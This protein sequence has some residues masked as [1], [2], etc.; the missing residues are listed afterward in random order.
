MNDVYQDRYISHQ[1]RKKRQL[2]L[3]EGTTATPLPKGDQKALLRILAH[4]RSQRVFNG[5]PL[6][7]GALDKILDAATTSP[8]SCNRHGVL[9]KVVTDRREKELLTGLL[10]GGVGWIHRADT[11][12]LFLTDPAAYK[13]PNEKD[14][15][16]YCDVGFKAMSMWLV[17]ETLG[18][19]VS[20]I[21]P[22][23]THPAIFRE[24]YGD[25]VF[26]GA[27]ALGCYDRDRR[28]EKA[29]RPER[30]DLLV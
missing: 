4:R 20:Y 29:D 9:I 27:L 17:A 6:P 26:C 15:M 14:F 25:H 22:N 13:S 8:N 30:T 7:K 21:N 19:G 18:I 3:S 2:T 11:V 24:R 23:L 5:A 16:H 28:A 12:L 10:V 1:A